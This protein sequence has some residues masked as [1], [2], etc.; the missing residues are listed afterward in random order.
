MMYKKHK[1]PYAS[2]F[3][4]ALKD[5]GNFSPPKTSMFNEN[6]QKDDDDEEDEVEEK[7]KKEVSTEAVPSEANILQRQRQ[8]EEEERK[9][10]LA[11]KKE[12]LGQYG[13]KVLEEEK[14]QA[15][16]E[17]R[18]ATKTSGRI[19]FANVTIPPD[20][21]K[22][23]IC[24]E[25]EKR[26]AVYHCHGCRQIF[27]YDCADLCHPRVSANTLQH[28]HEANGY[29]RG[30]KHGDVSRVKIEN[31]FYLPDHEVH[32]E[33]FSKVKDLARANTLVTNDTA[34]DRFVLHPARQLP[35]NKLMYKVNQLVLFSDP[36]TSQRAYGRVISEYDQRHGTPATPAL[37][38]GED[39]HLY[40]TLER[41]DLLVHADD[42]ETLLLNDGN[43]LNEKRLQGKQREKETP[44]DLI[45][46]LAGDPMSEIRRKV[47]R[48]DQRIAE[49]QNLLVYGPKFHLRDLNF[50]KGV[51]FPLQEEEEEDELS[52][53]ASS[54]RPHGRNNPLA[55]FQE[56][57]DQKLALSKQNMR[58]F[59]QSLNQEENSSLGD[60]SQLSSEDSQAA[61]Q[62]FHRHSPSQLNLGQQVSLHHLRKDA[63]QRGQE[64]KDK[65][66]DGEISPAHPLPSHLFSENDPV[67]RKKLQHTSR[68]LHENI[69][70]REEVLERDKPLLDQSSP[71]PHGRR[72]SSLDLNLYA[73]IDQLED[74]SVLS[75]HNDHHRPLPAMH[76]SYED[77]VIQSTFDGHKT[78]HYFPNR[79][80]THALSAFN[81]EL[82][83]KMLNIIVLAEKD[84]QCTLQ[85]HL[86]QLQAQKESLIA[87][88]FSK[89][90]L[91]ALK[92][93]VV[94]RFLHWKKYVKNSRKSDVVEKIIKIQTRLRVWL[95]RVS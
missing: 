59:I 56:R 10:K 75:Y 4:F 27:C 40:Y 8:M 28:E 25:C 31:D 26:F 46:E 5:V 77:Y 66:K 52:S 6:D 47:Q 91:I 73:N 11:A 79:P 36:F 67:E 39:S 78:S 64:S 9:R 44:L 81:Q 76:R 1:I 23:L 22:D 92:A 14:N 86:R 34:A 20:A 62:H 19:Q 12:F 7:K 55:K 35:A 60:A 88:M 54:R 29:I 95:C 49:Y 89:T 80:S 82:Q 45:P 43:Y 84:I 30:L 70:R 37:L 3:E 48:I 41:I 74:Q 21:P 38:R 69:K 57:M 85:D 83:Q 13:I 68:I 94:M 24:E 18:T 72:K 50:P 32:P 53:Q 90:E 2:R 93:Q 58:K 15:E 42:L 33:E 65:D 61:P 16:P 87:G 17:I 51:P 71:D 63:Q